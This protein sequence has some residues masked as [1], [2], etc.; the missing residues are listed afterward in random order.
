MVDGTK[1]T[2]LT[3][4]LPG[5]ARKAGEGRGEVEGARGTKS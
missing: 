4:P 1:F 2:L 5:L 3:V